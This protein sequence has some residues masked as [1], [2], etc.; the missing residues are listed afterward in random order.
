MSEKKAVTPPGKLIEKHM[1][2]KAVKPI[3]QPEYTPPP[4]KKT[5]G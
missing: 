4:P 5:G 2:E 1:P 3:P